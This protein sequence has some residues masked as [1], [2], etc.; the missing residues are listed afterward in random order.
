MATLVSVVSSVKDTLA[1]ELAPA[2]AVVLIVLG[3]LAYGLAQTQP[4]ASRGKWQSAAA[5]LILGGLVVAAIAGAA[6][7]IADQ[8]K[9][10][11]R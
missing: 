3:G 9:T 8:A 10:F 6:Q 7:M 4:A 1:G 5:G 2:V 11:L